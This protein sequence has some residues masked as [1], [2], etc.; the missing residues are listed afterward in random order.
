MHFLQLHRLEEQEQQV[1]AAETTETTETTATAKLIIPDFKAPTA[2]P[3]QA[4]ATPLRSP[5]F[6]RC[7]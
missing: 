5:L 1:G 2:A 7:D 4:C 3:T 6:R